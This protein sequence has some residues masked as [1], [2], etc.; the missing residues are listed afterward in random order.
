MIAIAA[1]IAGVCGAAL[2]ILFT[3]AHRATV[4]VLGFDFPYGIVLGVLAVIAFLVA[5]RLLWDGRWPAVGG[6]V[7]LVAALGLMSFRGAGGSVIV[8]S[9]AFGWTWLIVPTALSVIA[10]VWPRRLLR[11]RSPR[12]DAQVGNGT[13]DGPEQPVEEH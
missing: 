7:G 8:V 9:D 3:V 13:M 4:E 5:M 6:A 10:V 1:V 2:G 11:R 12:P